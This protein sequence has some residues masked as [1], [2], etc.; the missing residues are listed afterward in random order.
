M[1]RPRSTT[2]ICVE[3]CL[4]LWIMRLQRGPGV[5]NW[6]KGDEPVGSLGYERWES[7]VYIPAQV[8]HFR[9]FVRTLEAHYIPLCDTT[10]P[11]NDAVQQWF[12]CA[13]ERRVAKLYLP[14]AKSEFRC[15]QCHNL[16]YRSAQTHS[17]ADYLV[18]HPEKLM[19]AAFSPNLTRQRLA[20]KAAFRIPE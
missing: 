7:S 5:V 13:C 4:Y 18:R 17:E 11:D 8:L 16:T 9:P 15:R 10:Q 19:E 14:P 6:C 2:R 20:F 12:L 3:S 1:A